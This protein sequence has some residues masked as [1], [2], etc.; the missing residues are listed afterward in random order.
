MFSAYYV[1]W[2]LCPVFVISSF[3][4]V[5]CVEFVLSRINKLIVFIAMSRIC[6]V[7]PDLLCLTIFMSS[8]CACYI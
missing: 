8:V 5:K 7:C 1:Q 3:C 4:N 6:H 2:L